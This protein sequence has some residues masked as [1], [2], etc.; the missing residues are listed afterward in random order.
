MKVS[1]NKKLWAVT[2]SALLAVALFGLLYWTGDSAGE[3]GVGFGNSTPVPE[4]SRSVVNDPVSETDATLGTGRI[5]KGQTGLWAGE[6]HSADPSPEPPQA[7]RPAESAIQGVRASSIL[8]VLPDL[9]STGVGLNT[10]GSGDVE[11][12]RV[13]D[14]LELGMEL[15]QSQSEMRRMM[16]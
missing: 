2:A 16:G 11:Q 12:F 13:E 10:V 6:D 3:E 14:V 9:F 7:D 8:S 15:N 1:G 4:N 5:A